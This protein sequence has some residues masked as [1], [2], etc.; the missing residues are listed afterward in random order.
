MHIRPLL[1]PLLALVLAAC[2]PVDGSLDAAG[3]LIAGE[4]ITLESDGAG[5]ARITP[6]GELIIDGDAIELT[7]GQRQLLLAYRSRIES[8]S[9]QGVEIGKQGAAFGM[10]AAKQAL[11]GVFSGKGDEIT[12]KIGAQAD[13]LKQ[14]ALKICDSLVAL[15]SAQEE[16]AAALPEFAPYAGLDQAGIDGCHSG[17]TDAG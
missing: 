9:A 17:S 2:Q 11:T 10:N 15:K 14:E 7:D 13:D 6:A 5:K 12:E 1:L 4:D 16:L 8:I 3:K